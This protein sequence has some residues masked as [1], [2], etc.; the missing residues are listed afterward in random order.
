[1]SE[2]PEDL[3]GLA[4][5]RTDLALQRNLLALERTFAAWIRTGLAAVAAGLG[6]AGLLTDLGPRWAI[7]SGAI[8]L[9]LVGGT[10]YILALW[11]YIQGY[12]RLRQ[13]GERVASLLVVSAMIGALV[14]SAALAL[15]ALVVVF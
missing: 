7:F 13:E 3:N 2:Y 1:M 9:V 14:T 4:R 15:L 12:R 5:Q 6:I 11:R 10:I 8:V